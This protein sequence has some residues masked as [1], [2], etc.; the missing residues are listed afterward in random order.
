MLTLN[1]NGIA[2]F[3]IKIFAS[4]FSRFAVSK[5]KLNAV[6]LFSFL[7]KLAVGLPTFAQI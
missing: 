1:A 6:Y 3:V 5:C 2:N 7:S 4:P